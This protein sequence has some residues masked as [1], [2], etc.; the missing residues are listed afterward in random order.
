M[1]LEIVNS[2]IQIVN[3]IVSMART[4][5]STVSRLLS[6]QPIGTCL[7]Y[8]RTSYLAIVGINCKGGGAVECWRGIWNI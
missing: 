5:R 3:V 4:D 6:V 2:F 1:P 8:V 7:G